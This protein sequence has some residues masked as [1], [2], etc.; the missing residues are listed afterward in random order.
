MDAAVTLKVGDR[1]IFATAGS[2]RE[3]ASSLRVRAIR[4]EG[5]EYSV[6]LMR[7]GLLQAGAARNYLLVVQPFGEGVEVVDT[8]NTEMPR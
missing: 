4:K 3:K 2:E 5:A 7:E 6:H 8:T 1:V